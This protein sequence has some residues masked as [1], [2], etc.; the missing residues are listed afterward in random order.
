MCKDSEPKVGY[1]EICLPE[2]SFNFLTFDVTKY[3]K[4]NSMRS[5]YIF[6]FFLVSGFIVMSGDK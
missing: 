3:L 5:Y 2:Y 6:S 1:F 4:K